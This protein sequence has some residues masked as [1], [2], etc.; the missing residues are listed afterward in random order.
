MTLTFYPMVF[1][2]THEDLVVQDYTAT[3]VNSP[4]KSQKD[5]L[6]SEQKQACIMM[7]SFRRICKHKHKTLFIHF[8]WFATYFN[9]TIF[10]TLEKVS[11]VIVFTCCAFN[12]A[13][14]CFILAHINLYQY[15][16]FCLP[17]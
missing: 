10:G 17:Y 9:I 1:T 14:S 2:I 7:C 16:L 4:S 5:N 13:G 11:I 8:R 3:T 15:K 12:N 6:A